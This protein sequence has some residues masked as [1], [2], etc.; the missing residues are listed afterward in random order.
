MGQKKEAGAPFY[1][2]HIHL[3]VLLMGGKKAPPQETPPVP[4]LHC[5]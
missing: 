2:R 4:F 3:L 5:D 1:L